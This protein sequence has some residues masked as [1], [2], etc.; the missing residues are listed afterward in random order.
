MYNYAVIVHSKES[1]KTIFWYQLDL[2]TAKRAF[3]FAVKSEE[4]Y[5]VALIEYSYVERAK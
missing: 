5:D 3:D 4:Y 2:R 1:G